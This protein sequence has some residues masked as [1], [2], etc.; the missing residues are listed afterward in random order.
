[1]E[2]FDRIR[3]ILSFTQVAEYES[4]AAA[5]RALGVSAAAISKSIAGLEQSL[6]VRLFNRT[7]RSLQLTDEGQAFLAHMK[8]AMSAMDQAMDSLALQ[9]KSPSGRVRISTGRAFGTTCLLPLLTRLSQRYPALEFD[10]D[11]DERRVN[12]I[13]GRYDLALRGGEVDDSSLICRP[14]GTLRTLL[15]A[16]PDYLRLHGVPRTPEALQLHRSITVYYGNRSVARWVFKRPDGTIT[17]IAP[18]RPI[19]TTSAPETALEAAVLG[20]GVAQVGL[21]HA[22]N[23][24]QQGQLKVLLSDQYHPQESK[25]TLLYPH[26][27]FIPPRVKVTVA[28]LLKELADNETLHITPETLNEFAA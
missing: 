28:Y 23:Y 6:G 15:V 26:R 14:V 16:A 10:L 11:L 1:M 19:M 7:T 13:T 8:V 21:Y 4:F 25:M 24:I 2:S 17:E 20:L 12:L 27:A 3:S 18:P 9:R 5:A 22:W